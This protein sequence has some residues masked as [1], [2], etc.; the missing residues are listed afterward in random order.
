MKE[1]FE[2]E[3][4]GRVRFGAY[5]RNLIRLIKTNNIQKFAE[6]GVA[7]GNASRIIVR[8]CKD[9]IKEYYAIDPWAPCRGAGF[10]RLNK[11]DWDEMYEKVHLKL[12]KYEV[13][14][15]I[16]LKSEYAVQLFEPKSLDMVFID[17]DHGFGA[18]IKDI[19][20]WLPIIRDGGLITG[21]DYNGSPPYGSWPEVY[22]AVQASFLS[23][24]IEEIPGRLWLVRL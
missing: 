17:G 14:K 5:W 24:Q 10:D 6:I 7:H 11:E 1:L 12:S 4:G 22:K 19:K 3:L 18:V 2:G 8:A 23:K 15:I 20:F 13:I 16:R 9:Q 21:H